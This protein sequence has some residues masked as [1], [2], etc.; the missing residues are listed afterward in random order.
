MLFTQHYSGSP[1]CAPSRFVLLT[2]RHS[3]HAYIRGNDEWASRGEV[4]DYMAMFRDSTL[5]GQRP[6]PQESITIGKIMQEAG[7]RTAAVGKWGLG[8]PHTHGIP[9]KQGFDFFYGY[10]CQRQA[11]TYYPLHLYKNENRV[12]LEND[13][14]PPRIGLD[15]G[16]D[17]YDP[18]SY[19][20]FNLAEYAPD[21]MFAEITDFVEQNRKDPFFL[22][23]ATPI[24]HVPLQST[25]NW[26]QYY[27]EKFGDEEPYSA[28]QGYYPHRYP[29][30]CYAAMVSYLDE[31]VGMLVDQ[32]KD[33][34]LYEN[35][36]I[37]FTSD[38]GPTYA[39][40]AD[41]PWFNSGGPFLCEAGRGKG[42]LYEG[43]IRVPMIASWPGKIKPGSVSDHITAFWD[44]LP[45]LCEITGTPVPVE[46]DGIS[47]LPELLG[48]EAQATH[49]YM[50][51]EFPSYG[52]QQAVRMG[53]WKAIR[54]D[55]FEGNMKLEL[56]DLETDLQEQ[57]NLS[58]RFPDIVESMEQIM[59]QAHQPAEIE[60]FKIKQL[61][62]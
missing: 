18:E 51:W 29:H 21:M 15:E 43:G 27:V 39:G 7:F 14:V 44:V 45:T 17:P 33:L 32:L 4:W 11:H 58:D 37:I 47:Y 25:D 16:A 22:Y 42:N 6:I 31:Q 52:G 41:S 28:D 26:I 62:D 55:I 34:G 40:G 8:A 12:Y 61:G 19:S 3:G 10:N 53:K 24:P 60:R 36:L 5:E 46:S 35:T 48:K 56:Y 1:V 13:S 9:N 59:K 23:W 38:N 49:D 54:K 2:G 50:Y 30:A 20:S 57:V